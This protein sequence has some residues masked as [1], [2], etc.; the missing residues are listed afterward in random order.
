M[1]QR[2]SLARCVAHFTAKNLA[3]PPLVETD[4]ELPPVASHAVSSPSA[5]SPAITAAIGLRRRPLKLD[6]S[7]PT[8]LHEQ[9]AAQIR[10]SIAEGEAKP[11]EQLPPPKTWRR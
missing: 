5:A 2:P 4:L 9:V 7:D 8:A 3:W 11:G 10:R 6:G 1:R